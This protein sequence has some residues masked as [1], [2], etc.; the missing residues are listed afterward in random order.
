MSGMQRHRMTPL[1]LIAL[2]GVSGCGWSL[3]TGSGRFCDVVSAPIAFPRA[4]AESVVAGAR[5]EAVRIDAQNRY[6]EAN[7]K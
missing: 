4:V 3:D 1:W 7:C 2:L 6:W 5:E